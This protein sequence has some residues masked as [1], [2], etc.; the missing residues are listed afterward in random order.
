MAALF[1]L[2]ARVG[3]SARTAGLAAALYTAN[4]NFLFWGAQYS[5]ESL[6]LP[7][8]LLIM[9]VLA[10][11]ETAPRAAIR[12]WS[13]PLVLAIAAVVITHHLTSYA[14][15]AVLVAV[16]LAY[17]YVR[18]TWKRPNPWPFALLTL[19]VAAAWLIVVAGSTIGYLSPVLSGAV[20]AVVNTVAGESPP[21]ALFHSEG[22]VVASTPLAARAVSLLAIVI[23]TVGLPFGLRQIWRRFRSQPF[24]LVFALAALGFFA[25]LALRF[26]P[27]AWEAGNRA[28][29]FLFVGLAFVL[30]CAGLETW[31]PRAW[32]WLGRVLLTAGFGVALVGGAISGW[33]WD[34][35]LSLPLR[36]SAEGHVIVSPPLGVAEWAKENIPDARFAA[37]TADA[38]LLLAPGGETALAGE[39]PDIEDILSET[40]FVGWELPLLHHHHLR[41]VVVDRRL[42]SSDG[43]RG[44]FFT[45][46]GSSAA[47]ALL[48]RKVFTKFG[49]VPNAARIY[50]NGDIAVY[51]LKGAQ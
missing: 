42:V 39:R 25:T 44:Y 22:P 20:K 6:A 30:A 50:A 29:E 11:R 36:A 37:P 35:Q 31:R 15:T 49:S 38:R 21:R 34:S 3:G 43:L 33:P 23:F 4:F 13:V 9:M 47:D 51:D 41:Y 10:E 17:W 1:L 24:A 19:A 16:S 45:I 46:D 14:L 48:P 32:P 12:A 7:L 8:L 5:Y 26:T 2:F 18:R 40:A 27:P 28:S